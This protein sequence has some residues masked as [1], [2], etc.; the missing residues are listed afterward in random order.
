MTKHTLTR[1]QFLGAAA[2]MTIATAFVTACAP[3][4]TEPDL[5]M[6]WR[7]PGKTE[8]EFEMDGAFAVQIN[9]LF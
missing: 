8:P 6:E 7:R 4:K 1:R 9:L 2:S 5:K 3:G